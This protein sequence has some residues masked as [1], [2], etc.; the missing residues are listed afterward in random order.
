MSLVSVKIL[1]YSLLQVKYFIYGRCSLI[2]NNYV[3]VL[4][5][6][7]MLSS[8]DI[9]FVGY[10]YKN[11]EIVNDHPLPGIGITALSHD[12]ILI[13]DG[14]CLDGTD[15]IFLNDCMNFHCFASFHTCFAHILEVEI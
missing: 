12:C 9:N 6:M 4:N 15:I 1:C 7:Q 14:F 3:A 5:F 11:F 10:T 8:K 2:A 13:L